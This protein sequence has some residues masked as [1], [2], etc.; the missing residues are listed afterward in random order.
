M[1]DKTPMKKMLE[2]EFAELIINEID[3]N[4]LDF[5]PPTNA[6]QTIR[7]LVAEYINDFQPLTHHKL[8]QI[9]RETYQRGKYDI[10]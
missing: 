8:F 10:V 7:K 4:P 5:S 9:G 3:L 1:T 2:R 6:F